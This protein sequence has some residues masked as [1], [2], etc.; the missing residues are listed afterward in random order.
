MNPDEII[1]ERYGIEDF[2]NDIDDLRP[3]INF[4]NKKASK[5]FQKP[6]SYEP[7]GTKAILVCNEQSQMRVPDRLP[8]QQWDL[9]FADHLHGDIEEYFNL[10]HL[11][12]G[13]TIFQS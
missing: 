12:T 13:R 4:L 1:P 3:K 7:T 9:Y 6:I 11:T 8:D 5:Y 2:Q 10:E